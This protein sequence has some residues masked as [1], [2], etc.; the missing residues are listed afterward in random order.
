MARLSF[1]WAAK[2]DAGVTRQAILAS[3]ATALV[4]VGLAAFDIKAAARAAG[5]KVSAVKRHFP[6]RV[7]LLRAMM[8]DDARPRLDY[9]RSRLETFAT[10]DD[11]AGFMR[12]MAARQLADRRSHPASATLREAAW[13]IPALRAAEVA[14]RAAATPAL[15]AVLRRRVPA[16]P[17]ARALAAARI[18]LEAHT[19]LLDLLVR[20]PA[21]EAGMMLEWETLWLGY[22]ER[23]A[24]TP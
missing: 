17:E 14:D 1:P 2:P 19:H 21:L 7:A 24:A 10:T 18:M 11:P 3:A 5:V 8:L 12:A 9:F 4:E 15:A 13:T 6:D 22:F 20:H 16:L 23:S